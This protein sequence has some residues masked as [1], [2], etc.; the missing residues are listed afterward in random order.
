M[1]IA[2]A[3]SRPRTYRETWIPAQKPARQAPRHRAEPVRRQITIPNVSN[4]TLTSVAILAAVASVELAPLFDGAPS[5]AAPSRPAAVPAANTETLTAANAVS[6]DRDFPIQTEM[7]KERI[8]RHVSSGDSVPVTAKVV[9]PAHHAPR[10]AP[11]KR[12]ASATHTV[13]DS[14]IRSEFGGRTAL[15]REQNRERAKNA[16][17]IIAT[18]KARGLSDR[19]VAI[20][21]ATS[22]QESN[23][24]NLKRAYDHD[25]LGL[26]QQRPSIGAWGT[27]QQIVDPVH[28]ANQF[29]DRLVHIPDRDH[30]AM[31]SVA[32]QIQIPNLSDYKARWRWDAI[33]MRIV[34]S[35]HAS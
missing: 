12:T 8:V 11:H 27:A 35:Y 10:H 5:E 4:A 32:A 13:S 7:A 25:S 3:P 6:I 15:V 28:A 29:Y 21:V 26:F 18:G 2:F 19:S 22:I 9:K 34:Q 30:R 14:V 16:A 24:L 1:S 20:A 33:A 17:I 31:M 23:L